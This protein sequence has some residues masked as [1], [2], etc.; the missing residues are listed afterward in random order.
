[1]QA[2]IPK[3]K[4]KEKQFLDILNSEK[5]SAAE[6]KKL[7]DAVKEKKKEVERKQEE[8]ERLKRVEA[9]LAD[10]E[11]DLVKKTKA[12]KYAQTFVCLR[13]RLFV[14]CLF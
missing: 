5:N 4:K 3:H 1:M 10:Q 9:E 11:R 13:L 6:K 14:V 12:A 7:E 2:V 8:V